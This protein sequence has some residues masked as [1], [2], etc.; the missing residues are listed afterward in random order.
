[1]PAP[2]AA[3]DEYTGS[4]CATRRQHRFRANEEDSTLASVFASR[5]RYHHAGS[6]NE[7]VHRTSAAS[8]LREYQ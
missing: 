2:A 1:M 3:Y 4:C 7:N 5:Q 6:G 8:R